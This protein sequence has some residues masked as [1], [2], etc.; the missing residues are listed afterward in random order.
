MLYITLS[1]FFLQIL[2]ILLTQ[3]KQIHPFLIDE[4]VHVVLQETEFL[5]VVDSH[6]IHKLRLFMCFLLQP[7]GQNVMESDQGP[8]V[9][10]SMLTV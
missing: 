3:C 6:L 9:F 2:V 8:F 5:L 7:C 1:Y 4:L 10:S